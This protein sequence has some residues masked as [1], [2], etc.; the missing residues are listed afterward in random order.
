[1]DKAF[2]RL[3]SIVEKVEK[4]GSEIRKTSEA[5]TDGFVQLRRK[6]GKV[7]QGMQRLQRQSTVAQD[8]FSSVQRH[9]A[10]LRRRL[11]VHERMSSLFNTLKSSSLQAIQQGVSSTSGQEL[12]RSATLPE[13]MLLLE[14][15]ETPN[16]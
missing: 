8:A 16:L 14:Q 1:M 7:K 4:P 13:N 9:E 15:L 10:I 2:H 5:V 3:S 11:S 12:L 6:S